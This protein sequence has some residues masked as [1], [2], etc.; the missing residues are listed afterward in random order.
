MRHEDNFFSLVRSFLT[1]FLP[2]QRCFSSNTVKAYRDTINLYRIFCQER[3]GLSFTHITFACFTHSMMY[4]FL[5]WLQGIRNCSASTCNNRLAALKAFLHYCAIEEPSLMAIYMN[6]KKVA[7]LRT[8][9]PKV[10]YMTESALKAVLEQPD[11]RTRCGK[12]NQFFMILL[13]DSG[14]RIHEILNLKIKDLHL[15]ADIPCVYLTGKGNK[16]RAV[17]LLD[18]TI[19]HLHEYLKHFHS[20]TERKNDDFLFYTTSTGKRGKMSEDNVAC[21]LKQYGN[22]AREKCSEVPLRIYPHLFRHTRAM[23]LYQSGVPLSYIKDFLGHTCVNTTDI[24]ASADTSMM[25]A[26]LEKVS[27]KSP[28]QQGNNEVPIW[29]ENDEMILKL[30][31]LK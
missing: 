21:F 13:Y 27:E 29:K 31:G 3:K 25:R 14:A 8:S 15:N 10:E 19:L 16:T 30:C 18:K 7:A 20:Q 4:E 17:P 5:E 9:R 22:L 6:S 23:H 11:N 2:K 12:R 26:A 24:Y 28:N 1:I